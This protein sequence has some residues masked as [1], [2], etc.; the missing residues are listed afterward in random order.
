MTLLQ[1]PPGPVAAVDGQ[2]SRA[3]RDFDAWHRQVRIVQV[4]YVAFLTAA[5]YLVYAGLEHRFAA[6]EALETLQ[7]LRSLGVCLLLVVIGLMSFRPAL[8]RTMRVLLALAPVAAVAGNLY[9]NASG[10]SFASYA[11]EIYLVI[12]WTFSV[13]GLTLR[14]A[15]P[16]ALASTGL[17]LGYTAQFQ[18]AEAMPYLHLLWVGSALAFGLL[19]AYLL[20]RSYREM[21]A[22]QNELERL[23]TI[24]DLTGLWNQR[25]IRERLAREMDRTTRT[26][27]PLS[28]IVLDIDHFKQI[29]DRH[30][31]IAGDAMLAKFGGLLRDHVRSI[32]IVGRAGGEE[33]LV[34]LPETELEPA[35]GVAEKLCEAVRQNRFGLD[36]HQTAS[37]GVTRHRPGESL[38][39]LIQRAD[40]VMYRAKQAGRDRVAVA[41]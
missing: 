11:P 10:Q 9:L 25:H 28:L 17:I 2:G 16:S 34:V 7:V 22:Q 12:V 23:A 14:H 5:L 40:Q 41:G 20:E 3:G 31:H 38:N 39:E 27:S 15:M 4:R 6:D 24:D 13:S 30:G 8:Y 36:S 35:R 37:F 32:D 19:S 26:G 29:N 1:T 21:F 18:P 33:F